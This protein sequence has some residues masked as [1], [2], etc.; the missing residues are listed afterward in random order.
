MDQ[1]TEFRVAYDNRNV[2]VAIWC[3]DSDPDKIVLAICDG[4]ILC[5]PMTTSFFASIPLTMSER[6]LVS[7]QS[8]R[9]ASGWNCQQ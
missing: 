9:N 3:W 1:Q 8:E 6:L 5:D 7:I 2:Y 4:M